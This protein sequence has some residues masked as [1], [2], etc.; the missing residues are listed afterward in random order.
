MKLENV[1]NLI[2]SIP[3]EELF[4][5]L[6]LV[7]IYQVNVDNLYNF[8]VETN[9]AFNVEDFKSDMT[10]NVSKIIN[11]DKV[12]F[13]VVENLNFEIIDNEF[14]INHKNVNLFEF[15]NY[16][17]K[18]VKINKEIIT[19]V[20]I[21]FELFGNSMNISYPVESENR[22][23]QDEYYITIFLNNVRI[24]FSKLLFLNFEFLRHYEKTL[25]ETK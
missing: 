4:K 23:Y 1:K 3:E 7:T 17:Q 10:M 25:R 6:D 9:K 16:V 18:L 12:E 14:K 20:D 8:T 21:N 19:K 2:D 15:A 11:F 22:I 24:E 5:E 13:E